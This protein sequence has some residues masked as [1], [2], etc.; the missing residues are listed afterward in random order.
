LLPG[1]SEWRLFFSPHGYTA[2][3]TREMDAITGPVLGG[4]IIK[5][6]PPSPPIGAVG[7][8]NADGEL[9]ADFVVPAQTIESTPDYRKR[10]GP[11]LQR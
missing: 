2:W 7:G 11:Q 8:V 4:P 6:F 9:W 10:P 3:R 5:P 1:Q